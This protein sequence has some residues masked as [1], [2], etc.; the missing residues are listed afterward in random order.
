[1]TTTS[2]TD[3]ESA[4]CESPPVTGNQR[5]AAVH[6]SKPAAVAEGRLRASPY[7]SLRTIDCEFHEGMLILRGCLPTYYMKQ[8]AQAAVADVEGVG[9]VFNQ[10]E[11]CSLDV[12][13]CDD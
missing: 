4:T 12:L 3:Q 5:D 11:V 6:R 8:Q 10:I 7:L 9:R 1:M 13:R 2:L